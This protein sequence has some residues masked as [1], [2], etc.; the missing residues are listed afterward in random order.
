MNR[1]EIYFPEITIPKQIRDFFPADNTSKNDVCPS[2][3]S[4]EHNVTIFVDHD[5]P[6]KRAISGSCRFTLIE[7]DDDGNPIDLWVSWIVAELVAVETWGEVITYLE[8]NH[9]LW[10]R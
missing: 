4:T 5:N 8:N 2:F 3:Y 10:R 9:N 6:A 1:H 7:T